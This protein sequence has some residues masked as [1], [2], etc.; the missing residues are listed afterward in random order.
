M[1]DSVDLVQLATATGYDSDQESVDLEQKKRQDEDKLLFK[2]PPLRVAGSVGG[3]PSSAGAYGGYVDKEMRAQYGRVFHGMNAWEKHKW[4]INTF[5]NFY[6]SASAS[7][8]KDPASRHVRDIDIL[9]KHHK[10]VR[11][12]EDEEEE[13]VD[14]EPAADARREVRGN[15]T[16]TYFGKLELTV[17]SALSLSGQCR[18]CGRNNDIMVNPGESGS[19]SEQEFSE[20]H[21][22]PSSPLAPSKKTLNQALFGRKVSGEGILKDALRSPT[23]STLP[24][25]QYFPNSM[26]VVSQLDLTSMADS[27]HDVTSR[28]RS[29][30]LP[31]PHL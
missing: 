23:L 13:D 11:E 3:G 21:K 4:Y 2:E 30:T 29:S 14:Q 10:F 5:V 27:D 26:E 24:P 31:S 17:P 7:K 25:H 6:K 20:G 12:E 8:D 16:P 18:Y 28:S 1:G 9:K 22:C 15:M 19:C